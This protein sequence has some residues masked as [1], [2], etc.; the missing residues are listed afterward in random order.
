ML[1]DEMLRDLRGERADVIVV[2]R[3]P[4]G[5][6]TRAATFTG[7]TALIETAHDVEFGHIVNPPVHQLRVT[8]TDGYTIY[9]NSYFESRKEVGS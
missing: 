4:D 8:T 3:K 7:A 1:Y 6:E 9:D 2:V 5:T